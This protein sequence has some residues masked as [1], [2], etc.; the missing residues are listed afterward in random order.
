MGK[1]VTLRFL[2]KLEI[3]FK[4]KGKLQKY[5]EDNIKYL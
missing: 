3:K 2:N 4:R 5:T 1:F